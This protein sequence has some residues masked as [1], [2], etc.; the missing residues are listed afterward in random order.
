MTAKY[1]NL[2]YVRKTQEKKSDGRYLHEL[3]CCCGKTVF[4]AM[5]ALV[6]G[7]DN[8]SCGCCSGSANRKHG[9][10][11]SRVYRIWS[12]I[13]NRSKNKN[14]KDYKNGYGERGI[15]ERWCKF[16]NFYLDMGDPPSEIHQIDRID[17]RL[18]YSKDNCRWATP[19]ENSRNRS[20]SFIWIANGIEFNSI[21]E[22]A[23][24]FGH[25]APVVHRW[26]KGYMNRGKKIKPRDG[27]SF[28]RRYE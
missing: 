19:S 13:K 15:D 14:D 18:G 20:S 10:K 22:A 2:T 9:K 12:G 6:G 3:V 1:G 28:R 5:N 26:F 16:E 8:Q 27:F 11:N 7:G 17:N 21:G 4:R 24:Y 23:T 25:A